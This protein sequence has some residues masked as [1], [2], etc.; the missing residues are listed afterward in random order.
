MLALFSCKTAQ[1]PTTNNSDQYFTV[2]LYS[3]GD[4]IDQEAKRIV[5]N[6]VE[7]YTKKGYTISYTSVPWGKEGEVDYCF[8][9]QKLDTKVYQQFFN[10]LSTLLKDRR[11]HIT[12]KATCRSNY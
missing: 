6:T 2:S 9:L 7:V 1:L 10:E 8:A 11:V 12:E 3:P 4:G 5:L